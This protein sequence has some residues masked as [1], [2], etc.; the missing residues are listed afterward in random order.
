MAGNSDIQLRLY[1]TELNRMLNSSN[2]DVGR[3]MRRIAK[4]IIAGAK[5]MAPKRTGNLSRSIHLRRHARWARGQYVEIGSNL[6][7]AY[8]VHEGTRPHVITSGPGRMLTFRS[9]GR[10]IYAQ[11]VN[12]PGFRGRKYLTEP[13][14]RVV[15]R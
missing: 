10:R 15:H 1:D 8:Y 5:V 13:M 4:E 2:G 7:Y 14:K 11:S 12:H 3:Y 9:G 6:S